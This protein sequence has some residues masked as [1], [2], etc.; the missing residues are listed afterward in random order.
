MI[1]DHSE[2]GERVDGGVQAVTKY[3]VEAMIRRPDIELHVISF[4]YRNDQHRSF[5][6]NGYNRHVLAGARFGT[7]TGFRQDQRTLD[8][9]LARIQPD[10]VHGQ[11]A[12]HNGIIAARSGFPWVIPIHG[13]LAEEAKHL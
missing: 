7:L 13:I 9:L 3:L 11:G 6:A 10:V 5:A 8:A 2:S 1:T 12:G 4:Q